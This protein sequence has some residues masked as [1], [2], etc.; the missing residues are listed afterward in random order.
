MT[1]EQLEDHVKR[2]RDEL[3]KE[4]QE[5]NYF[6]LER[7]QQN[8]YC[9][10]TKNQLEQVQAQLRN[11]DRELEEIEEKHQTEIK[12]YK[13]KVKHL[14]YEHQSH[15]TEN[16]AENMISL[17]LAQDEHNDH[18]RSTWV[19]KQHLI[20][21]MQSRQLD[22]ENAIKTLKLKHDEYVSNLRSQYEQQI[23]DLKSKYDK[24]IK[25]LR[26]DMELTRKTEVHAVEERKNSQISEL[27]KGHEK[28]FS[29]IKNYYNDI[30]LNNLSLIGT[31][32]EQIEELK[33]KEER[34]EKQMNEVTNDNKNLIE[35][36]KRAQ[37]D[38]KML[39]KQLNNYE[40]DK[41]L[42]NTTK[43]RLKACE[44][45]LKSSDWE[46]EVLRQR[47]EQVE[48]ERDELHN[49]FVSA[50]HEVQQKTSMKNILLE[51]KLQTLGQ[52][53]EVKEAQLSK[54]LTTCSLDPSE[55]NN[56]TKK[57]EDILNDKNSTIKQLKSELSRVCKA[58]ND[59]LRTYESKMQHFGIPV[60][61]LGFKP[62]E[63]SVTMDAIV[64]KGPAGLVSAMS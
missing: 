38:V 12:V 64:G 56:V 44:E 22:H 13:Q 49:R 63:T 36:L 6:Q 31:L 17:K 52:S 34:M 24:K 51:K 30:T 27:M 58:H 55:L 7:D 45:S 11:K 20:K 28:A 26:E 47:F 62:L 32:K 46:L 40:K 16:K 5:R 19:E 61:E 35:P 53:L 25:L 23:T 57:L 39:K 9:E 3:D 8:A 21:S 14:L 18:E 41:A 1:K 59:L 60:A 4:R 43:A 50:I 54:L 15:L 29:E 33:K 42:L 48:S 2:L 37:D 10:I